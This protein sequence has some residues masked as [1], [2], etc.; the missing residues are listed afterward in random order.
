MASGFLPYP[1]DKPRNWV[2]LDVE[3]DYAERAGKL[4]P[5]ESIEL[6]ETRLHRAAMHI[7]RRWLHWTVT[8]ML[9]LGANA[10]RLD[11]CNEPNRQ[12][13]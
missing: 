10:L 9:S 2:A 12:N 5:F 3:S 7:C 13:R 6:I 1:A 4:F 8:Q 11:I